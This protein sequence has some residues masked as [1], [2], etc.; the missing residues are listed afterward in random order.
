[1]NPTRVMV[2]FCGCLAL[3]ALLPQDAAAQ[4]GGGSPRVVPRARPVVV[5]RGHYRPYYRG[6]YPPY[7]S[8]YYYGGFGAGFG[9]RRSPLG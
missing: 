7:F 3:G 6:Y 8:P 4:R 2:V 1:M 5:S 9:P